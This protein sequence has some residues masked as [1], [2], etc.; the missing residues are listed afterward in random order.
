MKTF[1]LKRTALA[2]G[3]V[4]L[5]ALSA[6]TAEAS[7]FRGAAIV[8]TIDSSGLLSVTF[9]SFW[10]KG[11][12]NSLGVGSSSGALTTQTS[13]LDTSDS[14]FDKVTNTATL[15]LSAADAGTITLSASSCCRVSGIHNWDGIGSSSVGWTMNSAIVWDGASATSPILFDFSAI[16]PEVVRG[17]AYSDNL[18]A[19]SGD[20]L[21]LTYDQ[22][23]N[24]IPTQPPGFNVNTNTGALTIA[25]GSP[26][27]SDYA[28]NLSNVGA[29]YAFS[30]HINASNGSFVE[31]DWLFDGVDSASNLS[32]DVSD[33]VI[34]ALVGNVI[35][36]NVAGTD[37]NSG[38]TV[39][40]SLGTIFGP[41]DPSAV[42]SFTPGAPGNPTS[43]LL[44][45]NTAGFAAGTYIFN[46]IGSDGLLTDTGTVTV[47]L[48]LPT[49]GGAPGVPEPA[50]LA[51]FG[52][53][54]AGLGY[55]RRRRPA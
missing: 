11:A 28:D 5:T 49:P 43:G 4:T 14:R 15:Q 46:I 31:F 25:A 23:L 41:Q 27:S 13:V 6:T 35:N 7:H 55:A 42:A 51:L 45:W 12:S 30:G 2:V 18:G 22:V 48:R 47:N 32:P 29:D 36:Q 1:Q 37:P 50:T 54:L 52:L 8:P 40:L 3:M 39:S 53:G 44:S 10:R 19:T 38:D 16:N 33:H 20:G 9:T 21:T 24:G 26:G 34:N 17:A